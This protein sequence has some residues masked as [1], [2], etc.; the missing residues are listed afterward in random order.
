MIL[1]VQIEND[2][3]INESNSDDDGDC[4]FCTPAEVRAVAANAEKNLIPEKSRDKYIRAYNIFVNWQQD[5]NCKTFSEN[6][7]L[8]YFNEKSETWKPSTLWAQ[9]SMLRSM[10]N[11]N[12]Q[13]DISS[14][15]KLLAFLKMKAKGFQSKKAA[16][17]T[18]EEIQKFLTE[19]PDAEY[20]AAKV[21]HKKSINKIKK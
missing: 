14:Y 18:R 16:V 19:A 20:L 15:K 4:G 10:M 7:F 8:A 6:V 9:Y 2:M 1:S 3:D 11:L 17:F 21:K 12:N 5:K 13:I